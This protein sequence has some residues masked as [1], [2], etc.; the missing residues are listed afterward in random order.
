MDRTVVE[1]GEEVVALCR[2]FRI[3]LALAMHFQIA[4]SVA[5]PVH[6][7]SKHSLRNVSS[8]IFEINVLLALRD[9]VQQL[10][11]CPQHSTLN[12]PTLFL[13][14]TSPFSLFPFLFFLY[15]LLHTS[16]VLIVCTE[17]LELTVS[18][19]HLNL[20]SCC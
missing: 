1:S 14:S 17:A 6:P 3:F 15:P 10:Q 2:I 4:R 8:T 12:P 16:S 11:L 13:F 20:F 5:W 19:S 9:L 18:V 7:F